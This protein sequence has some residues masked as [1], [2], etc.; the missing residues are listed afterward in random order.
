MNEGAALTNLVVQAFKNY[1]MITITDI[2]QARRV[3]TMK[4]HNIST[5][6]RQASFM[7]F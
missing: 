2:Y 6:I 5:D 7:G 1:E 3:T 4:Q